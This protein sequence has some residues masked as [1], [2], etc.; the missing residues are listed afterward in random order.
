M[1]GPW[2]HKR[3]LIT[4]RTYPTPAAKGI[5]VSCTAGVTDEGEWIRIFPVPYRFL[6]EDKRFGKYQW[7]EMQARK[8]GDSRP[9][10][11]NPNIDTIKIVSGRLLTESSW[12]PR[13]EI[14]S[15]LQAHCLCCLKAKRDKDKYPTL[16]FFKPKSIKRL[17]MRKSDERWTPEELEKLRQFNLFQ[18]TPA[19][20]LEKIPYTFLYEFRCDEDSCTG[21]TLSCTDWEMGQSYRSW[22]TK[23]GN[24]W[25]QKFRQRY[26]D[27]MIHK[28][29]TH[30]Y[31]GTVHLHPASWII[32]GLFY[33]P[34]VPEP[35]PSQASL[36]DI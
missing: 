18:S 22:K 20:E 33:P 21:H 15:P 29:D 19:V 26:E 5:E 12:Q 8:A 36:F 11:F 17:I 30:F 3:V 32:V 13:K 25:E 4:V 7:V 28:Y 9:E 14:V 10:S 16:G 2:V 27:E 6:G 23:Y 24:D 1:P 34:P 31:V 35:R